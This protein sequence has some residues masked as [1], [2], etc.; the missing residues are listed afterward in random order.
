MGQ[1]ERASNKARDVVNTPHFSQQ[2]ASWMFAPLRA[3]FRPRSFGLD[4][5]DPDTPSLLV[6]NHTLYSLDLPLLC[7]EIYCRKGL[8]VRALGDKWHFSV[9]LWRDFIIRGGGV[10]G[11]RENCEALMDAREHV[12]VLP[13]GG[14]EVMKRKGEAYELIWKQ[15][16]GFA[17]LAVKH[18][19]PIIPFASIGGDTIFSIL[20]D[21]Q[22]IMKSPLGRLLEVAGIT[23]KMKGGDLMPPIVRGLGPTMVPR[24]ERFYFSFGESISTEPFRGSHDDKEAMLLLRKKVEDSLKAQIKILLYVLDQDRDEALWRRLL[25]RI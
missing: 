18:G 12:L 13:G 8:L 22:E 3:Y 20:V 21:A 16:T 4:N 5:L 7:A 25:K 17:R 6:G 14:R 15:R 10:D 19:Y 2:T 23:K 11:S 24:P 1:R 9:P